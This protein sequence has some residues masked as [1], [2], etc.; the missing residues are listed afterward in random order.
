VLFDGIPA[1]LLYAQDNQINAIVPWELDPGIFRLDSEAFGRGAILNQDGTVNS[2]KNPAKRGSVIS[3]F[4][5]GTGLITPL[6]RDGEIVT[7]ASRHVASAVEVV[8][9]PQ[10]EGEVLYAGGAP[11]L[12]AGLTQITNQSLHFG[13]TVVAPIRASQRITATTRQ[14]LHNRAHGCYTCAA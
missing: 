13:T 14:Q 2:K 11:T 4:A 3:I 7:D 6:P 12:A 5:T 1:P 9:H 10:L 8:F